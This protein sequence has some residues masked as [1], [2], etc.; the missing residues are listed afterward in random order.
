MRYYYVQL[1]DQNV[2]KGALETHAA[3]NKPNMIQTDRFRSDLLE[4]SYVNGQF[5]P[6]PPPEPVAE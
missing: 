1:N 6:P 2:V 4:W 5:V 3:I